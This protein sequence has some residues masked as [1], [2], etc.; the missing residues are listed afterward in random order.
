VAEGVWFYY[1]NVAR[2]EVPSPG[3]TDLFYVLQILFS[4]A[5]L[6]TRIQ[7]LRSALRAAMSL[8]DMLI[9]MAVATTVSWHYLIAPAFAANTTAGAIAVSMSYP[10]GDLGL[11]FGLLLAYRF[12]SG[13]LPTRALACIAAGFSIQIV[14]DSAYLYLTATDQ[15]ASGSWSDPLWALGLLAIGLSTAAEGEGKGAREAS[16]PQR[17]RRGA[18]LAGALLP[19]GSVVV[20]FALVASDREALGLIVGASF[21]IALVIVRQIV[22][23]SENA[24]LVAK[25]QR[26]TDELGE[27]VEVR[28][29]QLSVRNE[30]L[31]EAMR[32][33]RQLAYHD[34]LTGLPNRRLFEERAVASIAQAKAEGRPLSVLFLD[35]DRFKY[36][37]DHYGHRAG[38]ALLQD[39]AAR[40]RGALH[41]SDMISRQGGDEFSMLVESIRS[42]RDMTD[43]AF[44]IGESLREPFALEGHEVHITG[45]IG[46]ALFPSDGSD[47]ATLMKH[48][49]HAMYRAKEGGRNRFQYYASGME[50]EISAKVLL[51]NEL[52]KALERSEL[53]LEYQPLLHVESGAVIGMEALIRWRHPERGLV[54]PAQFIPVAEESG[55]IVGISAWVLKEACRHVKSLHEAGYPGL[56]VSVNVSVR[57]FMQDDLVDDVAGVLDEVGLHPRFLDLELTESIS[58]YRVE[59]VI[60]KLTELRAIGASISIDDFGTGYSSLSYL[61]KFPVNTLK[62][63]RSFVQDMTSNEEGATI[64]SAIVAMAHSLR[65]RVVAEGVETFDQYERLRRLGCDMIQGYFFGKPMPAEVWPAFLAGR[66]TNAGPGRT[67]SP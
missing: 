9:V 7:Y 48:A 45:S 38:D 57:Q 27:M 53:F 19:Y 63:D 59:T 46:I 56:K 55:L 21:T 66:R 14:T 18:K 24:S 1:E 37:N 47:L 42:P 44:R 25:L 40:L 10:I 67:T 8:F 29:R 61:R 16:A 41:A 17:E 33:M 65:F 12:S 54:S 58:A 39:I 20:M 36:I 23:L 52:H 62:I 60:K 15:Y 5:A 32:K 26:M 51:E 64:V 35:V 22:L 28:T 3:W 49:D 31:E 4:I 34:A 6:F 43:I 11:L 2:I 50:E 13:S 30:Q